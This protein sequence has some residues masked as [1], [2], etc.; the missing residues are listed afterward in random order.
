MPKR[1]FIVDDSQAVR[2]FVRFYLENQLAHVVCAEAADGLDAI[3][4]AIEVQPDLILLDLCMPGRNGLDAAATLH[5][6]LPR[7]PIILYTL[8]KDIVSKERAQSAG[9]HSVVSK[10]DPLDVLLGEILNFVAV[11]RSASA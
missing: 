3:K 9:I 1:I 11:A 2:R 5:G 8:H 6:I 10:L 7:V 4:R